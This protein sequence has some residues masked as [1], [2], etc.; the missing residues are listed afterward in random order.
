MRICGFNKTTL[1]DYPGKVASTIFL[2]GL[3]FHAVRSVRMVYW[4][5]LPENSQGLQSG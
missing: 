2:G 3:Q 5:R 4:L 1:L